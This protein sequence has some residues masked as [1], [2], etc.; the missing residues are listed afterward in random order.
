MDTYRD[1]WN[2]SAVHLK[3]TQFC[4]STLQLLLSRFSRVWLCVTPW[5]AAL[6]IPPSLGFSRQEHW[7]GFAISFSNAWK[8]KVKVKSVS[9]VQLSATPRTAA[10]QAPPSMGF[11][12]QEYWSGV[13]LPSPVNQLYSNTIFKTCWKTKLSFTTCWLQPQSPQ[14]WP[15]KQLS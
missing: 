6:Q 15:R 13:P 14:Q 11:S 4:K 7:S 8:W 12:R 1:N 9:H 3:V 10:H 5:M 2:T